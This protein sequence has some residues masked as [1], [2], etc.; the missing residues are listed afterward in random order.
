MDDTSGVATIETV[1]EGSIEGCASGTNVEFV[2]PGVVAV[3]VSPEGANDGDDVEFPPDDDSG[4]AEVVATRGNDGDP[5]G[6]GANVTAGN[7]VNGF[8]GGSG[9]GITGCMFSGTT[10]AFDGDTVGATGDSDGFAE[11]V[12]D[13]EVEGGFTGVSVRPRVYG[14]HPG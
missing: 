7:N 14:K 12:G 13:G 2:S 3:V 5:V 9:S 11:A 4:A 8:T 1:M 10:G 6:F